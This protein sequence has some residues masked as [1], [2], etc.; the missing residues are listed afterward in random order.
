MIVS[1]ELN[2][3][4]HSFQLDCPIDISIPIQEGSQNPNCYYAAP[5]RIETIRMGSFVGSIADGGSCEYKQ[6]TITPHGNGT[7]T[8]CLTHVAGGDL[9]IN[10][11]LTKGHFV[12]QLLTIEPETVG[13]DMVLTFEAFMA[14]WQ[15]IEVEAVVIRSLPNTADKQQK[16]Y[17]GTNPP[18]LSHQIGVFLAEKGVK[19]LLVDLPSVDKE[20]DGGQLKMHKA[21][22][23]LPESP[24]EDAT[25]TELIYVPDKVKDGLYL[26]NLQILN[27]V[28]DA[29]PS[30][31][32][33][34]PEVLK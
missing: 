14:A 21:F 34:Y 26:L 25:I 20:V 28:S 32:V 12:A 24:R 11:A 31:P 9:T 1:V 16:Q 30:R 6:L 22:W 3:T 10:K 29:S 7:H 13:E 5:V 4:T 2:Q 19:H 23:C 17:S 18:Y 27:L 33:L 8:E 15:N